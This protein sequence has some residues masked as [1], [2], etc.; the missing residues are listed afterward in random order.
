MGIFR[1]KLDQ[2]KH[3]TNNA[4]T[5]DI[6]TLAEIWLNENIHDE[7]VHIPGFRSFWRIKWEESAVVLPFSTG[8]VWYVPYM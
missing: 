2:L 4:Q 6:L 8:K 3:I 1:G 7:E 5:F